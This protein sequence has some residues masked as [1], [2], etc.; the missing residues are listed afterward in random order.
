MCDVFRPWAGEDVTPEGHRPL[1]RASPDE[2][3]LSRLRDHELSEDVG[4]SLSTCSSDLGLSFNEYLLSIYFVRGTVLTVCPQQPHSAVKRL[5]GWARSPFGYS[6]LGRMT[7]AV[8]YTS[9]SNGWYRQMKPCR[10]L[11][12]NQRQECARLQCLRVSMEFS[13][14]SV[15][16][17][18]FYLIRNPFKDYHEQKLFTFLEHTEVGVSFY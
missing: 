9:S 10:A 15:V 2:R 4:F 14:A 16:F 18:T 5:A 11:L 3:Q 1:S 17:L 8:S 6:V 7:P 13:V 12:I